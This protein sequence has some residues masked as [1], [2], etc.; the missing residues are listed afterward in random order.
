MLPIHEQGKNM[1]LNPQ[2]S[3]QGSFH[4]ISGTVDP[5]VTAIDAPKGTLYIMLAPKSGGAVGLFQKQDFGKTT[6]WDPV[7]GGGSFPVGTPVNNFYVDQGLGDD[8]TGNGSILKPFK[9]IQKGIDS[10]ETISTSTPQAVIITQ[11]YYYPE[12]LSIKGNISLI[13][14]QGGNPNDNFPAFGG[15]VRIDNLTI[16]AASLG[17]FASGALIEN[18][19]ITGGVI[20]VSNEIVSAPGTY[21]SAGI[22]VSFRKCHWSDTNGIFKNSTPFFNQCMF[23]SIVAPVM[24]WDFLN[25]LAFFSFCNGETNVLASPHFTSEFDESAGGFGTVALNYG[26]E[27][28]FSD[29]GVD[30]VWEIKE[31]SRIVSVKT[32]ELSFNNSVIGS[33]VAGATTGPGDAI[34][35][36]NTA[37]ISPGTSSIDPSIPV[38]DIKDRTLL[39]MV[40]ANWAGSPPAT[41][42]EAL[43]RMASLL[44]TLNGGVPIP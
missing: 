18:I 9:T 6:N 17:S 12:S 44:K 28:E 43:E 27:P 41:V 34:R 5:T 21:A 8:A 23:F 4:T 40:S 10:A 33:Y 26:L 22:F 31:T 30:S 42:N 11:G 3:S 7:S 37:V 24:T 2:D 32:N 35:S 14:R 29:F 25:S 19:F 16:R 13:G 39:D 36:T 38:R 1:T 20:D 15:T